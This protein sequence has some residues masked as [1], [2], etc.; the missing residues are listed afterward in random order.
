MHTFK[1]P[2]DTPLYYIEKVKLIVLYKVQLYKVQL[3]ID[4][5]KLLYN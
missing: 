1:A 4:V 5:K 3:E 2:V